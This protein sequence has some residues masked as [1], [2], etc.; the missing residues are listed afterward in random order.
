MLI[1]TAVTIKII[2]SFIHTCKSTIPS[3][4]HINGKTPSI[5]FFQCL[6]AHGGCLSKTYIEKSRDL[7]GSQIY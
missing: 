3:V 1:L 7:F 4:F 6:F 5:F 2:S